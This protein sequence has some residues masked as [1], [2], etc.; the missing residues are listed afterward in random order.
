MK[1]TLFLGRV[2]N[3]W[4][5][6]ENAS[7]EKMLAFS[8][9]PT[10][11]SKGFFLRVVK[12]WYCVVKSYCVQL[13]F[14]R[15]NNLCKWI[16][17]MESVKKLK[18]KYCTL[19]IDPLPVRMWSFDDLEANSFCKHCGKRGKWWFQTFD[20]VKSNSKFFNKKDTLVLRRT[21][22]WFNLFPNDKF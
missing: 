3:I 11:L 15:L 9:F 6:G 14:V 10:T 7:K 16:Q 21:Y 18:A 5:K 4:G 22:N 13:T 17:Q 12:S 2:E 19:T 8:P 1:W 20:G